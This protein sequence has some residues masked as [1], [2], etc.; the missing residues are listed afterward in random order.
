MTHRA[1]S[2]APEGHKQV[3][4]VHPDTQLG[5]ISTPSILFWQ[6]SSEATADI[7][8]P[9]TDRWTEYGHVPAEAG[10]SASPTQALARPQL[11]ARGPLLSTGWLANPGLPPT[12]WGNP[13]PFLS[14][15]V[16]PLERVF[17]A[18]CLSWLLMTKQKSNTR[19]LKVPAQ[20]WMSP[21]FLLSPHAYRDFSIV[22]ATQERSCNSEIL[23]QGGW[24]PG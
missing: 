2:P 7:H 21:L 19:A 11:Q 6:L 20:I 1:I 23:G 22:L 14:L 17:I 5:T 13:F 8:R 10:G 24:W 15:R 18:T 16:L 12:L 9:Q 3:S 4:C